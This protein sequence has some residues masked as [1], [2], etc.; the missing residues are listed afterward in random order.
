MAQEIRSVAVLDGARDDSA[1]DAVQDNRLALTDQAMFLALRAT[2]EESLAQLVWVYEHAVNAD[3]VRTFHANLG[4][5]LFGRRIETSPLPFGRHR[6][7]AATGPAAPLDIEE[8]TRPRTE[9]MDWADER[10][11]LPLDPETGPGWRLGMLPMTDGSTAISLEISHCLTDGMGAVLTITDAIKGIRRDLGYPPLRSRTRARAL[12]TDARES[13]QGLP[14]VA[15]TLARTIRL[16]YRRRHDIARS[17]PPPPLPYDG[18]P[19][20]EVLVPAVTVFVDLAEWDSRAA[21]LRGNSHSLLAGFAARLGARLGRRRVG[22]GRVSLLIPI[23][24]RAE[25][26]T[27]ANAVSLDGIAVDPEPVTTDLTGARAAIRAGF[28]RRRD[29]PDEALQLLPLIPFIPKVAVQR[30][31]DVLFGFADL[32]VSCTNLG[33]VDPIMGRVDGTDAEYLMLRGVNGRIPR[34]LLEQRRGLLT[35]ASGRI[36]GL[37]SITVVGYEPGAVNTKESLHG[38]VSEVLA[39]FGVTGIRQAG[40]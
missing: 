19:D 34:R 4:F 29:E 14:E 40:A 30:G 12:R 1:T 16:A 18:N 7:V 36:G 35:V 15:R 26:D 10:A 5:G 37:I 6:W 17:A 9:L 38:H 20:A 31:A 28:Q 32:P 2:G 21:A 23:A 39:E 11:G 27:R 33:D 8:I 3:A 25:G 24:D 13:L 22:D